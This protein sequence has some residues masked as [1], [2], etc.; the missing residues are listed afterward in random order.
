M[1]CDEMAVTLSAKRYIA[2]CAGCS[3][4][5]DSERRDVMTCSG[6]C[7]VKAHRSGALK[8]LRSAALSFEVKPASILQCQAVVR[9]CPELE[10]EIAAGKIKLDAVMPRV[11]AAFDKLSFAAARL[12]VEAA[13]DNLGQA[14]DG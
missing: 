5:F 12:A 4:L 1:M 3:R 10:P 7:R 13:P 8:S 2:V 14:R 11:A 6:A 9:L